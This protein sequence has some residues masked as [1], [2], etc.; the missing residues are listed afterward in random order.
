MS[1]EPI[2]R[3]WNGIT[4]LC[5]GSQ[6]EVVAWLSENILPNSST[7]QVEI[8]TERPISVWS[9][10][11]GFRS[12]GE[13]EKHDRDTTVL[14]MVTAAMAK[15]AKATYHSDTDGMD[16]VAKQT[17]DAIVKLFEGE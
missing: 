14:H 10:L 2:T 5:S 15:Q 4:L 13:V 11:Q 1:E 17:A 16:L 6:K 3:V 12:A 9:F 7:A 8:D